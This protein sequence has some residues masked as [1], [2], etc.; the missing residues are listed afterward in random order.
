MVFEMPAAVTTRVQVAIAA[1]LL[2][3]G[4]ERL[5]NAYWLDR[6]WTLSSTRVAVAALCLTVGTSVLILIA[7][8]RARRRGGP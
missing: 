6:A 8:D 3:T 1:V 7:L 4:V 2:A 5:L